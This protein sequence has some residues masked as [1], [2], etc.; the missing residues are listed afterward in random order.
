MRRLL[1]EYEFI[2]SRMLRVLGETYDGESRGKFVALRFG[3]WDDYYHYISHFYPDGEHITS[4]GI[5]LYGGYYHMAYGSSTPEGER[6]V[7]VHELAHNLMAHLPMP[8]WLN[9]ALAQAFDH[10]LAGLVDRFDWKDLHSRR[11]YWN[12]TTVQ[13]FWSG[14]SFS[15]QNGSDL[16]YAL[17]KLLLDF[18]HRDIGP[19]PENF[20]RFV[21]R[22]DWHDAGDIAA[23]EHLGISLGELI[24]GYL[25]P[26]DWE[27]EADLASK[28]RPREELDT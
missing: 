27:P 18:I 5:F 26:G 15:C 3:D 16:S 9:E 23:R 2:L 14:A 7:R 6:Q 28:A 11:G 1:D 8:L 20:R 24:S 10:D 17:A 21:Q 22:A 12:R 13:D 4:G 25:G 19:S